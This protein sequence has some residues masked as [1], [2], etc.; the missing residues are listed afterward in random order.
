M[1]IGI[2]ASTGSSSNQMVTED[3]DDMLTEDGNTM[4]VE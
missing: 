2:L 1:L 3:G 4:S